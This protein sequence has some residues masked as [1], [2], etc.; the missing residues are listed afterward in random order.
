MTVE[1]NRAMWVD[2]LMLAKAD[3]F[4]MSHSGYSLLAQI[5]SSTQC[6]VHMSEC[7]SADDDRYA[8]L[9]DV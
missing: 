9:G 8:K 1:T 2:L 6:I 7:L 3:C 5:M 4:I